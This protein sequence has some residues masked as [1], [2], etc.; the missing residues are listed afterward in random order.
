MNTS[1]NMKKHFF[2]PSNDHRP[3]VEEPDLRPSLSRALRLSKNYSFCLFVWGRTKTTSDA[4][5]A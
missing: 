2:S 3:D 1:E 4:V 5:V